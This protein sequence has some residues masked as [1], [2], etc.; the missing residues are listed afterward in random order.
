MRRFKLS[1]IRSYIL[2]GDAVNVGGYSW[3]EIE[4]LRKAEHGFDIV[5][6][7]FG[8]AGITGGVAQGRE[9]GTFYA[10]ASRCSA[11]LQIF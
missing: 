5:G 8:A 1:E 9:T 2:S 10:V 4:D 6:T 3:K 7:S 11:L